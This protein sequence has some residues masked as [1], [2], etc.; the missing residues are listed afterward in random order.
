VLEP[1]E[2]RPPVQ[3]TVAEAES[4]A[5]AAEA[6][7]ET[8]DGDIQVAFRLDPQYDYLQLGVFSSAGSARSTAARFSSV[9]P[10]MVLNQDNALY[11]VL[12]G[13]LSPDES[14]ALLLNF[15]SQGFRDAFIR[16]GF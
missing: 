8:F 10:V 5:P 12:V 13:P 15:R 4:E 14:G 16:K 11:K 6:V 3:D 7:P 9:Y 2:E 1:A